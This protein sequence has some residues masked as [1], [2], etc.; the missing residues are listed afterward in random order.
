MKNRRSS[1]RVACKLQCQ[2]T[3]DG[4][5]LQGTVLDVSDRG[6]LVRLPGRYEQGEAFR[7]RL[8]PGTGGVIDLDVFVWHGRP[9][10]SG[11]KDSLLGMVISVPNP[12]FSALVAA[13]AAKS[14][15]TEAREEADPKTPKPETGKPRSAG[16]WYRIRLVQHGSDQTKSLTIFA[17]DEAQARVMAQLRSGG[18]WRIEEVQEQ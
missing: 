2:I 12:E 16:G 8:R 15:E 14:A 10:R 7:L 11:R 18:D 17:K 1:P 9:E 3:R 13:M 5:T 4:E 6:L